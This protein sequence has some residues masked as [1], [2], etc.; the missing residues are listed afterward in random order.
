MSPGRAVTSTRTLHKSTRRQPRPGSAMAQ[1]F[2]LISWNIAHRARYEAQAAAIIST[3]PSIVALQEVTASAVPSFKAAFSAAGLTHMSDSFSLGRHVGIDGVNAR[4][5][6]VLIASAWPLAV[7]PPCTDLPWPERLLSVEI[8]SPVGIVEAHTAYIPPGA[9]H[10]WTKIDTFRGIYQRLAVSSNNHRFLCGDFNIPKA[11]LADGRILTAVQRL[12]HDGQILTCRSR[13]GKDAR[14]WDAAERS[15]LLGLADFDLVDVFRRLHP[16]N[17]H[18]ASWFS[19]R[20][21]PPLARRF[22]H[23][24]DSASLS[25]Q[26]CRF[27]H[28]FREAGLSDHSAIEVQFEPT[29]CELNIDTSP[30]LCACE[31]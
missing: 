23:V 29:R 15:I 5:Y 13:R 16:D 10:G 6:G 17:V 8:A 25:P 24:F 12:A 26:T 4:R 7:L 28:E 2:S 18:E 20:K 3:R 9:S 14:D 1:P 21:K 19:T 30:S 27:V 11:E 22:D 31:K